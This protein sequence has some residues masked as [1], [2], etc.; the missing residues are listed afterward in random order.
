MIEKQDTICGIMD[1]SV[2]SNF[3][4]M[5]V[6]YNYIQSIF[7]EKGVGDYFAPTSLYIQTPSETVTN[8]INDYLATTEGY[9]GSIEDQL[10]RMFNSM[11]SIIGTSLVVIS[12]ISL[13]VS[14]IM[15]LVVLYMSVTE[16]TKEI[17]VLK[18]IGAR[19]KDIKRI[20]TSESFLVGVLSGIFG[21]IFNLILTLIVWLV[22]TY[23]IGL[24]PISYRW[25]YFAIALGVS[26]VI[27]MLAGLYPASKAAKLDPV[28]SLRR[29]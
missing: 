3:L 21:I 20:F 18:S 26:I 15:I 4:V 25:W 9:T 10:A 12:C 7:E 17:G 2:M 28:E 14:A 23:T 8:A 1:T 5:Y 24:A 22:L 6:D 19:R 27:S 29:E 11:S 16:R 13:F